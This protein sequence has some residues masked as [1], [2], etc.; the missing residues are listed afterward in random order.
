MLSIESDSLGGST[1]Y[2]YIKALKKIFVIEDSLAWHPNL[3]SKADTGK[4]RAPSFLMV[5]TGIG[6]YPLFRYVS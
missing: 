4:M 2:S 6:D 3:R 1:V 5:L